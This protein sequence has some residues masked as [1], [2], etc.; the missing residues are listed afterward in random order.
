L[1]ALILILKKTK[2]EI[3]GKKICEVRKLKGLTQEK[4]AELANVNCRKIN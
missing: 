4:L 1:L 3:D 2:M